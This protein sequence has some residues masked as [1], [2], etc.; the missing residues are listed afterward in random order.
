[1]Q[2]NLD[3]RVVLGLIAEREERLRRTSLHVRDHDH[4]S[5]AARCGGGSAASW[6]ASA[7]GW[8]AS[9]RCGRSGPDEGPAGPSVHHTEKE[10][11][12]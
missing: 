4:D 1:M 6:C 12:R 11:N 8:P 10:T 2:S 5:L 9:R 3:V 7:P